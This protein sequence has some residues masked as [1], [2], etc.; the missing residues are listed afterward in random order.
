MGNQSDRSKGQGLYF[1]V[2]TDLFKLLFCLLADSSPTEAEHA[3]RAFLPWKTRLL[4]W[5]EVDSMTNSLFRGTRRWSLWRSGS[6]CVVEPR[7]RTTAVFPVIHQPSVRQLRCI[8]T[9]L[10]TLWIDVW[11]GLLGEIKQAS[12]LRP[13]LFCGLLTFCLSWS[14]KPLNSESMFWGF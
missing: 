2:S 8:F 7:F 5:R 9:T 13:Y 6:D 4:H 1:H 11:H 3:V 10:E 14:L 12:N